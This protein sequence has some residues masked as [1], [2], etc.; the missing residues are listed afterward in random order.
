MEAYQLLVTE[1]ER[2]MRVLVS[3]R[4]CYKTPNKNKQG[5]SLQIQKGPV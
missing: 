1:E 3:P 4:L 2:D 5:Y